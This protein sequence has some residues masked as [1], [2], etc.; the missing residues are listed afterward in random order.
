M[1]DLDRKVIENIL[2]SE[3]AMQIAKEFILKHRE[4]LQ[5]PAADPLAYPDKP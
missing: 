1:T 3:E 2:A 5:A 4:S